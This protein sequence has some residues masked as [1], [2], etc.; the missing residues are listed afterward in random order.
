MLMQVNMEAE[1]IWYAIEPYPDEEIEYR[2]DR[3]TL[4]AI[5]RFVPFEMLPTLRGK[6]SARAAWD[7][8]KTIRVSVER[9]R[10]SKA[11]H[12]RREFAELTWKEGETVEDFSVRITGLGNNL[13]M[14]GDTVSDADIVRKLLDVVPE[15]LEQ[16]AVAAETLLDLNTVTVEEVTGRL[17]AVEQ[18]RRKKST[19]TVDS[20]GRLLLTQEEWMAKWKISGASGDKGSSSGAGGSGGGSGGNRRPGASCGRGRGNSGSAR[21][22]VGPADGLGP[23]KKTDKCRYC[24]KKGHW[25]KECRSRLRDEA[26][27]AQAEEE[28]EPMLNVAMAEVNTTSS[29]STQISSASPAAPPV[30]RTPWV[31]MQGRRKSRRRTPTRIPLYSY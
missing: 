5:L 25:T 3:L 31:L 10:E 13:R 28:E 22:A 4:V 18:R 26:H 11:Q 12:L 29:S 9:V 30:G 8:I 6:H 7:A 14:L 21:Q 15:Y 1:G 2:D 24:G 19:P 27:L 16:V 23:A 20:Q 17:R